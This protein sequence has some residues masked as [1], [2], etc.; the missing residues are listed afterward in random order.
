[1]NC[2]PTQHL[3]YSAYKDFLLNPFIVTSQLDFISLAFL[4][5]SAWFTETIGKAK[6]K[7]VFSA[8]GNFLP[9][10]TRQN[11]VLLL[12]TYNALL[13]WRQLPSSNKNREG[14]QATL[15]NIF[16][17]PKILTHTTASDD[18]SAD[19]CSL[20]LCSSQTFCQCLLFPCALSPRPHPACLLRRSWL[21]S[22]TK[23]LF[24]CI[25]SDGVERTNEGASISRY[26]YTQLKAHRTSVGN[27]LMDSGN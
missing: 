1:M 8:W 7:N 26:H 20:P 13:F 25:L 23:A 11:G 12:W 2:R 4:I 19:R 24:L 6:K 17:K 10:I 15:R 9:G 27:Y 14:K 18:L 3:G 16:P 22:E 5:P 21:L